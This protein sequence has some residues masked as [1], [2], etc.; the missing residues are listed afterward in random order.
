MKAALLYEY[1]EQCKGPDFLRVEAVPDPVRDS[2]TDVIVRIGGAGLCRTDL[3]IIEGIWRSKVTVNLPYIPGHENAGWIEEAG[4]SVRR[5]KRGD[6]V[7]VH[8]SSC[9]CINQE[10]RVVADQRQVLYFV[11]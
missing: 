2:D 4:P 1:D 11:L 3:H 7:I 10:Q 9:Q 5:F 8:P 6:A